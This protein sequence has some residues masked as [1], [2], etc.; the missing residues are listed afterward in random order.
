MMCYGVMVGYKMFNDCNGK[1]SRLD[2]K[3]P[4]KVLGTGSGQLL[5]IC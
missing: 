3:P 2:V 1:G 4:S 5:Y